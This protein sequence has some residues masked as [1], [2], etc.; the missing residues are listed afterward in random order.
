[1]SGVFE[2]VTSVLGLPLEIV[3]EEL[4]KRDIIVS[5]T[6][7]YDSSVKNGWKWK[8]LK[9]RVSYSTQEI[10]GREYR[11]IVMKRLEA[12]KEIVGR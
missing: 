10:Y 3:L 6:H 11:D 7:F 1:M 4:K 8:T 2:I 5:W 12:Y 9:E